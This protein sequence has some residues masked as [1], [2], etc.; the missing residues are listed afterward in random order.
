VPA[1]APVTAAPAPVTT[2]ET[3]DNSMTVTV[4]EDPAE[5]SGTSTVGPS[6]GV[7]RV[8]VDLGF[9]PEATDAGYPVSVTVENRGDDA[10]TFEGGAAAT[11][12]ATGEDGA[13]QQVT[14]ARPDV[15]ELAPGQTVRLEGAMP[16]AP[17]RYELTTEIDVTAPSRQ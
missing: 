17:G 14:I 3:A 12:R 10:I 9:S 4:S 8:R 1:P 11:V 2:T 16:L 5:S 15:T 13:V 6:E 7:D